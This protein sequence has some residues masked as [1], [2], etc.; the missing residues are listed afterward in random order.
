MELSQ[1]EFLGKK[2]YADV[3][4]QYL[5]DDQI[6]DL[7]CTEVLNAW[8][9]IGEVGNTIL[10]LTKVIQGPK[11]VFMDFFQRLTLAVCRMIPAS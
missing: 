8:Y 7:C 1:D 6:T 2:N 4:R 10:S 3:Q 9:R 11:E 5:Y